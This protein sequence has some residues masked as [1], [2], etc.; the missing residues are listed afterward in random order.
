[1]GGLRPAAAAAARGP[2]P[3]PRARAPLLAARPG[4][5]NRAGPPLYAGSAKTQAELKKN[6]SRTIERNTAF[7]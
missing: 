1:M 2:G 7:K 5:G 4:A 6:T 3:G